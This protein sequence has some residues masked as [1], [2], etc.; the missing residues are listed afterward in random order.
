MDKDTP[1]GLNRVSR[2]LFGVLAL[3][4]V[5]ALSYTLTSGIPVLAED[6][7][8]LLQP[9]LAASS[10]LF[11][12]LWW[13]SLRRAL[14]QHHHYAQQCYQ[15]QTQWQTALQQLAEG[16]LITTEETPEVICTAMEPIRQLVKKTRAV[17]L[18]LLNCSHETQSSTLRLQETTAHQQD[19]MSQALTQ[20]QALAQQLRQCVV[21]AQGAQAKA[22]HVQQELTQ[23]V[24]T[25]ETTG[26]ADLQQSQQ[27]AAEHLQQAETKTQTIQ[28][29][30]SLIGDLADQSNIL[31]LNTAMQAALAGEAGR[32][33]RVV[34]DEVQRLAQQA[35]NTTRQ[36]GDLLQTI[37]THQQAGQQQL[38]HQAEQLAVYAQADAR[39]QQQ[40][41]QLHADGT[42]L[43][44]PLTAWCAAAEQQTD[45]MR[46]LGDHLHIIDTVGQQTTEGVTQTAEAT[47]ALNAQIAPLEAA[48]AAC[49]PSSSQTSPVLS[50]TA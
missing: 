32:A 45:A 42:G 29:Q 24:S 39:Q 20:H 3:L 35:S 2:L 27:T 1:P 6:K 40:L 23:L 47:S 36:I 41:T 5:G 28:Q 37:Q 9:L 7:L 14:N 43:V 30:I 49:Q 8:Q 46:L 16:D 22:T 50:A 19:Q 38:Q 44:E 34:S 10:V 12:L 17:H 31:A 21:Q 4:S 26:L 25:D 33:F 48:L 13:L 15:Q 11:S 18:Q